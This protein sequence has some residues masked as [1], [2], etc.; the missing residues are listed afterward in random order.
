MVTDN[1]TATDRYVAGVDPAGWR[2]I[3]TAPRNGTRVLVWRPRESDDHVAHAGVDH[4]RD[5]NAGG[6][7]G[8][9]YRSRR[10]QQPT[11]WMPLPA[12]PTLPTPEPSHD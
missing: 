5:D 10:Y 7:S 12:P 4:W 1:F 8:S 11:H 2:P 3:E 9:W 6:G